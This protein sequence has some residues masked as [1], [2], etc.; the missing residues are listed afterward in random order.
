MG[1]RVAPAGHPAGALTRSG[2][3]D[4]HHPAL[5][6]IRLVFRLPSGVAG[7][8]SPTS[9]HWT[10]FP[11][12][13]RIATGRLCSA[14]FGGPPRFPTSSLVCSP[15]TPL[16]ASAQTMV[17]LVVD[18]PRVERFC[19]PAGRAF[20]NARRAGGLTT[21]SSASPATLVD[22]QGSPRL[23]DHLHP[24]RHRHTPR[25]VRQHLALLRRCRLLPSELLT[26]WASRD[27]SDFGADTLVAHGL[28]CLRIPGR[29]AAT[30][31]RLTTDLPG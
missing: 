19:E 17:S 24:T 21:G 14:G 4:F 31:A 15:P 10:C 22:R 1:C 13:V 9:R 8:C 25:R 26:S 3:G 2:Q 7:T 18:V 5:P 29:V 20:V 12:K 16:P 28:A 30:V 27:V 23:R 11:P 6:A